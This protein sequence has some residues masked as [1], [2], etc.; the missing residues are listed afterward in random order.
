MLLLHENKQLTKIFESRALTPTLEQKSDKK[1]FIYI[2]LMVLQYIGLSYISEVKNNIFS[3]I[4]NV[5]P[6]QNFS[7]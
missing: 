1:T 6:H 7:K 5:K 3:V 4:S 2:I